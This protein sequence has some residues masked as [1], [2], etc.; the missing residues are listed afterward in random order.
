MKPSLA[1][2]VA[3]TRE[4]QSLPSTTV[5]LLE[6]LDDAAVGADR[7]LD[8]IET[9]PA[10]TTNLLKLCNS[11]F[12]GLRRQVGTVREALVM[13]GNRTV[14]NLAFAASMG[15]ILS[16]PLTAYQ[17]DRG[18][19]WRH[20]LCSAL[21]SAQ[22]ADD[23]A[24]G[25][26]EGRAFT[27]GLVH[28]IGKLLLD[29]PLRQALSEPLAGCGFEEMTV[30]ERAV[31]GFDH[32][33]AGAALAEAWNFPPFLVDVIRGHHVLGSPAGEGVDLASV[34]AVAN[35]VSCR[36]GYAGGTS[37]LSEEEFRAQLAAGGWDPD[38]LQDVVGAIRERTEQMLLI[39]R[40]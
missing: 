14:V 30:R 31:L 3:G 27:A 17:L 10:L 36:V 26:P 4:L 8:V 18:D 33:E 40:V 35:L 32:A 23:L 5:R 6:F 28:D 39:L 16:G 20:A 37:L 12:Y 25:I 11:A 7:I 34:V 2:L 9:D 13:L 15:D 19:L 38:S 24:L 22:V 29:R 21:G 1:N